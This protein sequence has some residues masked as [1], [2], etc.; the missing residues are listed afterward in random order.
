M[1]AAAVEV[2][3]AALD[4]YVAARQDYRLRHGLP[5]NTL[6]FHFTARGLAAF[7]ELSVA[8]MSAA[9]QV[10]RTAQG[11]DGATRY[12]VG[13]HSY[14]RKA[15][16]RILATPDDDPH[17]VRQARRRQLVHVARD[18]AARFIRDVRSE[19]APG[20]RDS[21]SDRLIQ[22]V[23]RMH[24]ASLRAQMDLVQELLDQR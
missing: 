12:V 7:A 1:T 11:R 13:S 18:S 21:Q 19:V 3:D 5:D 2:V 14:G 9:L 8:D 20:L 16:W 23:A 10:Y 22:A 4:R 6:P 17:L 24:E 15:A